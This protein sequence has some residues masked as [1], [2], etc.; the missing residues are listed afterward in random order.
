MESFS[1]VQNHINSMQFTEMLHM[2]L[3]NGWN[4]NTQ[5]HYGRSMLITACKENL[6]QGVEILLQH[7][8]VVLNQQDSHGSSALNIA[9]EYGF[10]TI[11]K[12]LLEH[13]TDEII[14][15]NNQDHD[16]D[17]PLI[18]ASWKNHE[19]VVKLLLSYGA[20]PFLRNKKHRN[21]I[22]HAL[23]NGWSVS[24]IE[25]VYNYQVPIK[26]VEFIEPKTCYICY[27]DF[28][29]DVKYFQCIKCQNI[30]CKD[31]IVP[32]FQT[33]VAYDKKCPYC[34]NIWVQHSF[35]IQKSK[36]KKPGHFLKDRLDS[37]LTDFEV[38]QCVYQVLDDLL[39]KVIVN[40]RQL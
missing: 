7:G 18:C 9:S 10:Y 39:E 35:I 31:C 17:T 37:E 15:L 1:F 27:E 11:V 13:E 14:E 22:H 24:K 2:I 26:Y 40:V 12:M 4:P 19:K 16:G 5:N 33:K 25:E 21:C 34:A 23:E 6:I 29:E 20:N 32:W 36:Q 30:F 38:E 8:G 28:M 3:Q